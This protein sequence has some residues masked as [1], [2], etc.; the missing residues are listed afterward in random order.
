[1]LFT[2]RVDTPCRYI[3]SMAATK[4]FLLR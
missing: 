4:A 2:L 1:M 3:S